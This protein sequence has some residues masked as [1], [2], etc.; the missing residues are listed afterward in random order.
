METT[1]YLI[2]PEWFIRAED[3]R[4]N[5]L[6]K[7]LQIAE[8]KQVEITEAMVREMYPDQPEAIIIASLLHLK[9]I[10]CEVGKVIGE[11]AIERL[12]KLC[13]TEVN[14]AKCKTG[15]M[16]HTY[17]NPHPTQIGRYQ[18]WK[19]GIHRPRNKTEA[20]RDLKIFGF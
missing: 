7:G 5:I 10:T 6:T 2:K 8:I 18:Y 13:G 15:T 11:C 19:N 12:Y 20:K 16:R 3:I 4:E 17:G 9:G 14:P 1:M